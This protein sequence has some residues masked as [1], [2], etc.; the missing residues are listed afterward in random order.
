MA[1]VCGCW[2]LVAGGGWIWRRALPNAE[3]TMGYP[4]AVAAD[5]WT[6]EIFVCD[7]RKNQAVHWS[8]R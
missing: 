6:G 4:R 3:D 5:P 1:L 2:L 8:R 7:T